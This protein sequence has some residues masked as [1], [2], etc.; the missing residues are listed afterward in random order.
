MN[1]NG[2]IAFNGDLTPAPGAN[3]S[4]GVFVYSGG[5][6]RRSPGPATPCPAAGTWLTQASSAATSTSTTAATSSLAVWLTP[7]EQD[8]FTI[9]DSKT[10][11][12][13]TVAY[14]DVN[15]IEAKHLPTWAY[16]AIGA[17]IGFGILVAVLAITFRASLPAAVSGG[18]GH[19]SALV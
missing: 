4:T 3:E 15:Q 14:A 13:K 1:N 16:I 2:Q 17:G 11:T 19:E 10:G 7:I 9:T 12:T 6:I 8:T 5:K 18:C